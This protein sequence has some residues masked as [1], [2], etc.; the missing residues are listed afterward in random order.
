MARFGPVLGLASLP[1]ILARFR[2]AIRLGATWDS[3]PAAEQRAGPQHNARIHN[4]AQ[5]RDAG[6]ANRQRLKITI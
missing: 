1:V 3:I 4:R 5:A 6:P 2:T